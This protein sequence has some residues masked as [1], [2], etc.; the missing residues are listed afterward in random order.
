MAKK[1]I[2]RKQGEIK[3]QRR[4]ICLPYILEQNSINM[5]Y[6]SLHLLLLFS[7]LMF[8]FHS[9]W[10]LFVCSL[11]WWWR[12]W[13]IGMRVVVDQGVPGAFQWWI[14]WHNKVQGLQ[15]I[16]VGI[17]LG[18]GTSGAFWWWI[19]CAIM[20]RAYNNLGYTYFLRR[21][22]ER[23]VCGYRLGFRSRGQGLTLHL[24]LGF[25]TFSYY[26]FL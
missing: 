15:Q 1:K 24:G 14:W 11:K 25:S 3:L 7:F 26:L 12:P 16:G 4:S 2:K 5:H 22:K 20:F 10:P 19:Q 8:F 21:K 9:F 6:L 23:K 17:F 18:Q 13:S